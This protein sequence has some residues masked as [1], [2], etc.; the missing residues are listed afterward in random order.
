MIESTIL[1]YLQGPFSFLRPEPE[2]VRRIIDAGRLSLPRP[3]PI[4]FEDERATPM[5]GF[6]VLV[7]DR[8]RV[9]REALIQYVLQEERLQ[10]GILRREPGDRK[11]HAQAWESYRAHLARAVENSTISSHGRQF[12]ELFWLYH[13]LDLAALLKETPRRITRED[14]ELGR[15]HGDEIRFR[16]Y[17]RFVDRLQTTVYDLMQRLASDTDE[18]EDELFPRL[19]TRMV[20]NVLVLTEDHISPNL[21]ELNGYFAGHLRLDGRDLRGRLEALAAWHRA[22]LAEDRELERVVRRLLDGDPE[23][24]RDLLVRPGYVS[25]LSGLAGYDPAALLAAPQ[26]QVWEKLLLKLKEFELLHALR[27]LAVPVQRAGGAFVTSRDALNR[28]LVGR[29]EL[30]LSPT[31]R[32]ID[33][34]AP[35]VVDPQVHRFGMIYDIA[36]FSDVVSMLRRSGA[37]IQD[38]SFREMF[39]FQ[40]RINRMA[41]AGKLK[42]EKYLGD[43][44]FYSSRRGRR[45]L[46]AAIGVQRLYEQAL[47]EGF[48]FDRGIRIALNYG[49]Y[50]LIPIHVSETGAE[51]Y[52]FFGHGLVE[53]SR[54]TTGKAT[55]EIEEIKT[56][57]VNLGYREEVVHRFFAPLLQ[58]NV[59]TVDRREESRRFHAYINRNGNLVNEGIV[60]TAAFIEQLDGETRFEE[61]RRATEGDRRYVAVDLAARPAAGAG[62]APRGQQPALVVGL[63][64]LGTASLKG[65]DKLAAFEVVDLGEVELARLDSMHGPGLMAAIEREWASERHGPQ[66]AVGSRPTP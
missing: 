14:P 37:E 10:V 5:A 47:A 43:G 3:Q 60:A 39:R 32:P 7:S 62:P 31:T 57:L 17:D 22:R 42:L 13:S 46:V 52:E 26:V 61:L 11:A 51:R 6:P 64:K 27:R 9:L 21:A 33:F 55:R 15:R 53:L 34:M 41:D 54:L 12:P 59:D 8:L 20:D 65:L 36:D 58:Q 49:Q 30:R 24:D 25:Y 35:W 16:V 50:R 45:M 56:V 19:L 66:A 63:R 2:E 23:R 1:P 18:R 38:S 28:T 4:Y 29:G 44:A 40:R 48:P